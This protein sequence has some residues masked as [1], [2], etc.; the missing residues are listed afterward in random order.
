MSLYTVGSI[1]VGPLGSLAA[2]ILADIFGGTF[3]G[4]VFGLGAIFLAIY[5]K[6]T[7]KLIEA[8]LLSKLREKGLMDVV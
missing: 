6:R 1:G 7:L 4:L 5:M 3:S 2:G 8:P